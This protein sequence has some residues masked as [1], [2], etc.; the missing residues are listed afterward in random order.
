MR[1]RESLLGIP[2]VAALHGHPKLGASWEGFVI[3]EILRLTG[4]REAWFWATQGMSELDLIVRWKG[5]LIGFEMKC[6]DAPGMTK[7]LRTA[8][9]DLKLDRAFIV[10]PGNKSYPVSERV[11]V[12][13]L[14]A[15][16][17]RLGGG[18]RGGR[19]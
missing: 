2:D 16:R 18:S 4:D 17:K 6:S 11:E 8:I 5:K 7:S 19:A 12:V 10:Y 3:E 9:Q 1:Y 14:P 15:L 13:P